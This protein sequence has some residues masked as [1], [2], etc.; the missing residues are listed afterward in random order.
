M[1]LSIIIL[2]A[3]LL[4]GSCKTGENGTN[5]IIKLKQND[6]EY[7]LLKKGKGRASVAGD[8]ILFSLVLKGNTGKTLV[9]RRDE[10]TWAKEEIKD[11]DTT[12]I[13]ILEMLYGLNEG[14]SVMMYKPM[15]GAQRPQG[16][17]G[18]DTLIYFIKAE[19]ILNE[20]EMNQKVEDQ[21]AKQAL[22]ME[23]A[24]G[25][26][27]EVEKKVLAI[28]DDYKKGV[29]KGKLQKTESGVEYYIN[30]KGSGAKVEKG[31]K[32]ECAYYGVLKEDGKMFDNSFGRGQDIP[33][34]AGMGQ[35]IKGWDDAMLELNQGDKATLFIPYPLAYGEA[36]RGPV[37]PAK[38]DLVFYI[39]VNKLDK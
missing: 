22:E 9:E 1:R 33:F 11:V 6:S 21:K 31:D 36:G 32:V 28:L 12:T 18:V 20:E 29:L 23:A 25:V 24:K 7:T 37:I 27:A 39:E 16:L 34:Q 14:D 2:I 19:Q 30:E 5:Q 3:T 38:A 10:I 8:F 15:E 35:M 13:P 17:E 26:E 4:L